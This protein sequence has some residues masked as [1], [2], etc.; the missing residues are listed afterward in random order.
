MRYIKVGDSVTVYFDV[1]LASDNLSPSL[2]ETGGQPQV[3]IN[4]GAFSNNGFSTLVSDGYGRY[5][6]TLNTGLLSIAVGDVLRTRYKGAVSA[7]TAGDTFTVIA[8]DD[9]IPADNPSIAY[10]G[11]LQEADMYFSMQLNVRAWE[12]ASPADKIKSLVMATQ[13]IDRL[14]F[15]GDKA[16]EGQVLQFPRGDDVNVPQDIKIA[17]YIC[18]LKF[19]EGYDPDLEARAAQMTMSKYDK[20]QSF[21]E[22]EFIP[23]WMQVGIPS[24]KAW[25]LIR[26]YLLDPQ[27]IVLSRVS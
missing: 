5:H 26:P 12:E 16:N 19:L 7:E 11:T 23:E 1:R 4:S 10:Y 27:T 14:N 8:D 22:R 21:Y 17:T 18:G 6:A 24:A 13:I 2:T 15:A 20:A 9:S 25:N 3:S